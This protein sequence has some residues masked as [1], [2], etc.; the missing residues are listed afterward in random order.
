MKA[1]ALKS[2]I[3]RRRRRIESAQYQSLG[4][5]SL[6]LNSGYSLKKASQTLMLKASEVQIVDR[7]ADRYFERVVD[8][9][10]G[11]VLRECDEPLSQHTGRGSAKQ[12]RRK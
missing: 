7:L 12:K 1:K 3:S 8:P 11:E 10:A 6:N 5:L 4:M 9:D 2:H